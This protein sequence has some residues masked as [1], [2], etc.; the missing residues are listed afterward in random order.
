MQNLV[1]SLGQE[2]RVDDV[3]AATRPGPGRC[4]QFPPG[5]FLSVKVDAGTLTQNGAALAWGAH[6]Y[7]E[8]AL[9]PGSVTLSP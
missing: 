5:H 1:Q 9:D 4:P 2:G 6:G 7:Y 8:I 3:P